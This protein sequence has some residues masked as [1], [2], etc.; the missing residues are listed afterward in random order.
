MELLTG[1]TED[2]IQKNI[3]HPLL[4]NNYASACEATTL[5]IKKLYDAIPQNKRISYGIVHTV[6]LL[7]EYLYHQF[8]KNNI[9]LFDTAL[10]MY[11]QTEKAENKTVAL[12]MLSFQGLKEP[13]KVIPLFETAAADTDWMVREITQMLFRKIIKKHPEPSRLFLLRIV[14]S[15]DPNIRRFVGETLR[16]VVENKW[17]YKQPDFSLSVLKYLFKENKAYPRTSV[18]NNLSDLSRNL[19][20][21]VYQIVEELVNSG[22]KNS[23]WIAY[24]ACRNLVK[25]EPDRVMQLL[26]TDTYKYKDRIHN[27]EQKND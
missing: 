20:E 8:E 10:A 16:P 5:T 3:I 13:E 25:K 21:M 15:A 2:F 18:G 12:C 23:Y 26:K 17:F 6:K 4:K 22:D 19:P 9:P 27:K 24:R 11:Q 1:Q 14:K 7:G